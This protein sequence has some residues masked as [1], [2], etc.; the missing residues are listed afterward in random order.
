MVI[1][2]QRAFTLIELLVV[3]S[4]ISLLM[5]ILL[6]AL[7]RARETGRRTVCISDLKQ[8]TLAWTTYASDNGDKLV[9][10]APMPGAMLNPPATPA[11]YPDPTIYP[12][13]TPATIAAAGLTA[14]S[15]NRVA[16]AP[17]DKQCSVDESPFCWPTP[18]DPWHLNE[19]PWIGPA[20]SDFSRWDN[21]PPPAPEDCQKC[22][23]ETGALYKYVK[24]NKI[25]TC[26][27][28]RRGELETFSIFDGMNGQWM[29]RYNGGE[30]VGKVVRSLCYKTLGAIKKT[31]ERAVFIDEGASS[32]D[33][34]AVSYAIT[35]TDMVWA[36]FPPVRHGKGTTVSYADGHAEWWQYRGRQT[37]DY[38]RKHDADPADLL[39]CPRGYNPLTGAGV[40]ASL[41]LGKSCDAVNDLYKMQSSCWGIL[42]PAIITAIQAQMP[43]CRVGTD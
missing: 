26:P 39:N 3:I 33:S 25:Y 15:I 1:K 19:R 7:G 30:T 2:K 35:A 28:G 5:A 10:G 43:D 14:G 31:S 13:C 16:F 18:A 21:V 40:P 4:I 17:R 8:L 22:A 12:G 6:P 36:D 32:C 9:N 20:W 29:Y 34:Y 27:D 11:R 23:I 24:Q 42:N 37:L 41:G 38:G